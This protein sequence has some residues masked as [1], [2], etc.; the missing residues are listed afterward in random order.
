MMDSRLQKE[1]RMELANKAL[2]NDQIKSVQAAAKAY[3]VPLSILKH[4]VR[5]SVSHVDSTPNC[6]NLTSTE[7]LVLLN[8]IISADERGLPS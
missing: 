1:G 4:R 3:N 6:Q 2:N 8:W 5:G 7:E